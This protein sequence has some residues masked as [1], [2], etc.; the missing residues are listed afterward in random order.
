[1]DE[2]TKCKGE[3][4][5]ERGY[6]VWRVQKKKSIRKSESIAYL[7]TA[8]SSQ[9]SH[10]TPP[11]HPRKAQALTE[12][13]VLHVPTTNQYVC[14]RD[15][16]MSKAMQPPVSPSLSLLLLLAESRCLS[17]C[18]GLNIL[19]HSTLKRLPSLSSFVGQSAHN[20]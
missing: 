15:S 8:G 2:Q 7:P 18:A 19:V 14:V 13:G 12:Q 4:W 1:M 10:L 17:F 3:V 11:I 20:K 5:E 9:L 6:K 16:W